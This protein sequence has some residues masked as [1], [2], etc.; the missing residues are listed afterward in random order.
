VTLSVERAKTLGWALGLGVFFVPLVLLGLSIWFDE[1]L[2]PAGTEPV[3][4]GPAR[5]VEPARAAAAPRRP[6]RG[7]ATAGPVAVELRLKSPTEAEVTLRNVSDETLWLV[8]PASPGR[9]I[10]IVPA[11]ARPETPAEN[12]Y[13]AAKDFL[14]PIPAG[15]HY[16]CVLRSEK[17]F[18]EG[19]AK[20]VYDTRGGELPEKA[21]SGRAESAAVARWRRK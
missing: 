14:V 12:A 10:R 16:G 20:A 1:G 2:D 8:V 21:W 18:P 11:G 5:P 13:D 19:P 7:E 3:G 4:A 6:A 15:G 17:G 9:S